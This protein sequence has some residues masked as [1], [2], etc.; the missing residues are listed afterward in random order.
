VN[1][2]ELTSQLQQHLTCSARH[3]RIAQM[4]RMGKGKRAHFRIM[5]PDPGL[6]CTAPVGACSLEG[7]ASERFWNMLGRGAGDPGGLWD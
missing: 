1:F 5:H 2:K 6:P 7:S 3:T 4:G